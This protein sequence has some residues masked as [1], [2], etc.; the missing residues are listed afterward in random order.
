MGNSGI[1]GA[2]SDPC[3]IFGKP[4]VTLVVSSGAG[5]SVFSRLKNILKLLTIRAKRGTP[6]VEPFSTYPKQPAPPAAPA[7]DW[8]AFPLRRHLETAG[9][10]CGAVIMLR[11]G[12]PQR[13]H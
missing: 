5:A 6:M 9:N 7:I 12:S 13:G 11:T 4:L 10:Y 8:P 3:E 1:G 2:I